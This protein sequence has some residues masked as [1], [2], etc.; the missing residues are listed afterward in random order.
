[1]TETGESVAAAVGAQ[2][3]R[4]QPETL[5]TSVLEHGLCVPSAAAVLP[6]GGYRRRDGEEIGRR[7]TQLGAGL[8]AVEARPRS[9]ARAADG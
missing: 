7:A 3:A 5:S 6:A 2:F 8:A 1:M 4:R 9:A